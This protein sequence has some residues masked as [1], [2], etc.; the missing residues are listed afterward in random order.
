[1]QALAHPLQDVHP[2]EISAVVFLFKQ[3]I[4]AGQ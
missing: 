1:M 2:L 3:L 4:M